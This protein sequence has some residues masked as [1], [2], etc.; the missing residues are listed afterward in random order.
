MAERKGGSVLKRLTWVALGISLGAASGHKALAQARPPLIS[1]DQRIEAATRALGYFERSHSY[2]EFQSVLVT[3]LEVNGTDSAAAP[4]DDDW[5]VQERQIKD[6]YGVWFLIFR[7]LDG[8]TL[9]NYDPLAPENRC[10]LNVV[11]RGGFAGMDPKQVED[12][13]AR[14]EYEKAL[15]VNLVRC[16][17]N[18]FQLGLPRLEVETQGALHKFL[19]N[20]STPDRDMSGSYFA[21]A[22]AKSGLSGERSR[23]MWAIFEKR[24]EAN[25]QHRMT[26]NEPRTKDAATAFPLNTKLT[27]EAAKTHVAEWLQSGDALQAAWAAHFIVRDKQTKAIPLLLAYVHKHA[28]DPAFEAETGY[29]MQYRPQVHDAI[30]AMEA[31][32]DALIVFRVRVPEEDLLQIAQVTPDEALILAILPEPE[33]TVLRYFYLTG[34]VKPHP[35][36]EYYPRAGT[37]PGSAGELMRWMAAGNTLV[38]QGSREFAQDVFERFTLSLHLSIVSEDSVFTRNLACGEDQTPG[39]ER[40]DDWPPVGNYGLLIPNVNARGFRIVESPARGLSNETKT[41]ETEPEGELLAPGAV[42]VKLVRWTARNYGHV[43]YAPPCP[44]PPVADVKAHWLEKLGTGMY[45]TARSFDQ[46]NPGM[47]EPIDEIPERRRG[48]QFYELIAVRDEKRPRSEWVLAQPSTALDERG[49]H[50]ELKRWLAAQGEVYKKI[51]EGLRGKNLITE[52]Q[53][54]RPL[55]I[56]I[57]GVDSRMPGAHSNVTFLAKA[58]WEDLTPQ[59]TEISWLGPQ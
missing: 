31:V 45:E 28:F 6:A 4:L 16:E 32:L 56:A 41:E 35:A 49:Y 11:P 55:K 5:R 1:V 20:L 23:D 2:N 52:E 13:G 27:P 17:R 43:R 47:A 19:V 7:A 40:G 59:D 29:L 50:A 46:L 48:F 36:N 34:G 26:Q 30:D 58:P 15:E 12:E 22:L 38:N 39:H 8:M 53:R 24:T 54:K 51:A 14:A 3:L 18:N 10:H 44:R 9:V 21:F 33:E 25:W 42:S 57:Y 37:N